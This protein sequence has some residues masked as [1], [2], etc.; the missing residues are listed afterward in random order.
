MYV[1]SVGDR[2]ALAGSDIVGRDYSFFHR[3]IWGGTIDFEIDVGLKVFKKN[4]GE[5]FLLPFFFFFSIPTNNDLSLIIVEQNTFLGQF[6]I[7]DSL[8]IW[9]ICLSP[10]VCRAAVHIHTTHKNYSEQQLHENI[11]IVV[12]FMTVV[13]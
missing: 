12:V 2:Q 9:I 3:G 1:Q 4:F 13:S 10:F 8:E 7:C 11:I 6:F 5:F